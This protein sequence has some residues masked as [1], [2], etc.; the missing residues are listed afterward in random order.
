M[1][2]SQFETTLMAVSSEYTEYIVKL[3][4]SEDKEFNMMRFKPPH[5]C[6]LEKLTNPKLERQEIEAEEKIDEGDGSEYRQKEREEARRRRRGYRPRKVNPSDQPWILK[7]GKKDGRHFIGRKEGAFNS[8]ASYYVM[9][10]GGDNSF[11]AYPISNWYDF[12]PPVKYN[13][14]N[15]EE[16]EERFEKRHKTLNYF[17]IMVNKRIKDQDEHAE[18]QPTTKVYISL[19]WMNVITLRRICLYT[20]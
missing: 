14:L 12:I 2:D 9:A 5:K 4:N 7:E 6:D 13:F 1:K 10:L 17:T 11:E 20:R 15:D 16:A 19:Q 8:S 3:G 18:E